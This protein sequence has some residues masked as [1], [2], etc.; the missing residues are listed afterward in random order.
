MNGRRWGTRGLAAR[1]MLAVV[2]LAGG[3]VP[4]RDAAAQAAPVTVALVLDGP[5][6]RMTDVRERLMRELAAVMGDRPVRL[7]AEETFVGD[8]TPTGVRAAL[9]RAFGR[10]DVDVVV[11]FG[12]VG[13]LVA[14]QLGPLPK[15]TVAGPV[16]EP[17]VQGFPAES[18]AAANNL[19]YVTPDFSRRPLAVLREAFGSTRVAVVGPSGVTDGLPAAAV[20]VAEGM[21]LDTVWGIPATDPAGTAARIPAEAD[22]VYVL[23]LLQ[24][25]DAE[26]EALAVALTARRLPSLSWSGGDEVVA[27][28]L[29]AQTAEPVLER[30][31]RWLAVTVEAVSRAGHSGLVPSAFHVREQL[32]LNREA[33]QAV[34]VSPRWRALV[35]AAYVGDAVRDPAAR[36]TLPDAVAGALDA[37]LDL[38][39]ASLGVEAGAATVRL[40]GS[41][42]LPRID[43]SGSGRLI[44]GNVLASAQPY[45]SS[46]ALSAGGTFV[47]PLYDDR[48]WADYSIEQSLQRSREATFSARQLDVAQAA[49]VVYVSVLAQRTFVRIQSANRDLARAN[50]EIARIREATGGGRLAEVYRWR[51]QLAQSQDAVIR[52][53][54][55]AEVVE[56]ELNRLLNRPLTDP[57]LLDDL[58][59]DD[60]AVLSRASALGA[61]VDHPGVFDAVRRFLVAEAEDGSPELR[62]LDAQAVAFE[63]RRTAATR[64]FWLP[65][66]SLEGGGLYRFTQWGDVQTSGGGSGFWTLALVGRY[67]LFGGLA[68][69]AESD[70]SSLELD[71]IGTERAAA[72]QRVDQRV[73][74]ALLRLR[75]ALVALE[76]AEEAANAA[77]AN[78]ALTEQS[79]REGVGAIILVLDAQNTALAAELRAATAAYEVLVATADVQRAVGRFD[80]FGPPDARE[81]FFRRLDAFLAEAG[82]EVRR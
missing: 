60:P 56:Q 66:V 31:P 52:S 58:A 35:E 21:G 49:S 39:A 9:A 65:S 78:Y 4:Q 79:Y 45:A 59:V 47:L 63:R 13:P 30:V 67:P 25:S 8:W 20:Q 26:L 36:L 2:A 16:L 3:V 37:N 18:A 24:W 75:G 23:P 32:T 6:A 55:D 64:A 22:G 81:D 29:A 11:L 1:A 19:H 57:V 54:T 50:L 62:A 72:R 68:R 48:R 46:G 70:R 71:R 34:G 77:R 51:T 14:A 38:S 61:Y 73:G 82:V 53:A 42:L 17:Q 69:I 28:L 7:G 76:V 41:P 33:M 12:L 10:A 27:G 43:V 15:P 44:G 40:A 74:S 5:Q 80:L